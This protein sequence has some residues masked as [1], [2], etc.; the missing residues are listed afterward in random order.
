MDGD[1]APHEHGGGAGRED[2]DDRDTR[3]ADRDGDRDHGRDAGRDVGRDAG[4]D[5]G[6]DGG[7]DSGREGGGGGG[8]DIASRRVYVGG[9]PGDVREHEVE[10][11]FQ[12]FGGWFLWL[13]LRMRGDGTMT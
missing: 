6:R 5:G 3:G 10:K 8:G 13:K 1:R 9:L 11:I 12:E 4:R 7:R 2:R